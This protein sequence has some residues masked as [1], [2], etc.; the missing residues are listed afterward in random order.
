MFCFCIFKAILVSLYFTPFDTFRS[1]ILQFI[2]ILAMTDNVFWSLKRLVL[3]PKVMVCNKAVLLQQLKTFYYVINQTPFFQ[4]QP[5]SINSDTN[6]YL[7]YY[8]LELSG[9]LLVTCT[10]TH[11][12]IHIRL[13]ILFRSHTDLT[14]AGFHFISI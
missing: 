12:P 7:I 8:C 9:C 11:T 10:H 6:S 13:C 1:V 5:H 2:F 4:R 14:S 3:F